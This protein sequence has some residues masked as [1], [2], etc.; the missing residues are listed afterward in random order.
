MFIVRIAASAALFVALV[1]AVADL[2]ALDASVVRSGIETARHHR[3][4]D[5]LVR[6]H[7]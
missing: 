2:E 3:P 4:V 7:A 6:R 1:I 5:P